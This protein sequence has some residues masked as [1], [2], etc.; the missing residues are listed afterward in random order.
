MTTEETVIKSVELLRPQAGDVLL[1]TMP[2]RQWLNKEQRAAIGAS[3]KRF[4]PQEI[5]VA[6]MPESI[7]VQV[8]R[9]EDLPAEAEHASLPSPIIQPGQSTML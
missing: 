3:F 5:E 1:V 8:V 6:I 4:C 2:E 9:K 7:K